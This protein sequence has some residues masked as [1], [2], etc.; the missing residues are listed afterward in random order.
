M[1]AQAPRTEDDRLRRSGWIQKSHAGG[2]VKVRRFCKSDGF[3][4]N[5]AK[6]EGAR[7]TGKFDLR[8]VER[9]SLE[10]VAGCKGSFVA[11]KVKDRGGRNLKII[12]PEGEDSGWLRLWASACDPVALDGALAA[13]RDPQL[14]TELDAA[15]S[16]QAALKANGAGYAPAASVFSPRAPPPS[17]LSAEPA[18]Q[19]AAGATEKALAAEPSTIATAAAP[20]SPAASPLGAVDGSAADEA[21]EADVFIVTVPEGCVPGASFP[22]PPR[23]PLSLSSL[24]SLPGTASGPPHHHRPSPPAPALSG[25]KLRAT[26]PYG[27]KLI[28]EVPEGAKPGSLLEYVKPSATGLS[29]ASQRSAPT[30]PPPSFAL[31]PAVDCIAA[32]VSVA[33]STAALAHARAVVGEDAGD[34]DAAAAQSP[35]PPAATCVP[36]CFSRYASCLPGAKQFDASLTGEDLESAAASARTEEELARLKEAQE[37][38]ASFVAA[39]R[40]YDWARAKVRAA[41]S[42]LSRRPVVD[43]H[44]HPYL[45]PISHVPPAPP[46][47]HLPPSPPTRTSHQSRIFHPHLQLAPPTLIPQA[48]VR[49]KQEAE[50]LEDSILRVEFLQ[51]YLRNG[52]LAKARDLA[53]TEA[54]IAQVTASVHPG[55]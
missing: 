25:D 1:D 5:Y 18:S 29:A 15:Y 38:D 35:G 37:H 24:S 27:A 16:S 12:F 6:S 51:Y 30:P 17:A 7:P 46:H 50:D 20:P 39:I 54:E 4:V 23:M 26:D 10:S 53:I 52:D 21:D 55:A 28:I 40:A 41:R 19:K 33:T 3:Q 36:Q 47:P 2:P 31:P 9:L 43:Q 8:Q 49:T 48:L 22:L 11:I 44:L 32:A 42:Q 34:T 14:A 13:M 45:P